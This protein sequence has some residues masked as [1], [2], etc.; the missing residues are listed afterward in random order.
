MTNPTDD[1]G[2]GTKTPIAKAVSLPERIEVRDD[3]PTRACLRIAREDSSLV[4]DEVATVYMRHD[5]E[6]GAAYAEEI[7]RRWNGYAA[8]ERLAAER[9]ATINDAYDALGK[10]VSCASMPDA[11]R[12]RCLAVRKHI[13]AR[14]A[15]TPTGAPR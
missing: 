5:P 10:A 3:H 1:G 9:E 12:Q 13:A 14:H 11:V 8:L 4:S 6:R 7:V 2:P 15:R